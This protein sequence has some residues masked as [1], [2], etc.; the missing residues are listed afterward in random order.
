MID[1][2]LKE[3]CTLYQVESRNPRYIT[4]LMVFLYERK[5]SIQFRKINLL[6]SKDFEIIIITY[7]T[8]AY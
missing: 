1:Y 3:Q 4:R 5:I 6:I 8:G 2:R 7:K